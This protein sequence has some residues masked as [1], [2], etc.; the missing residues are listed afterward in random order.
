MKKTVR[1]F[2]NVNVSLP[3]AAP[4]DSR[5]ETRGMRKDKDMERSSA[6]SARAAALLLATVLLATVLL[7]Q[8]AALAQSSDRVMLMPSG[9]VSG[10]V[11]ATSPGGVDVEK[12]EEVQKIPIEKI[13]EVQFAGEPQDLKAARNLLARGRPA[14]A[15]EDLKKLTSADFDGADPLVVQEKEYVEAAA[16]A[17]A[18]L[19]GGGDVKAAGG[20]VGGF[21]AKNAKSHHTFELQELLGDLLA[22]AGLPDKA[23]AA[24]DKVAQ[25]PP[26]FKVRAAS[27]KAR[28]LFDQ[29][30]FDEAAKA[31]D[32][33]MAVDAS[34][35]ASKA[36]KR[37]AGLGKAKCFAQAGKA[38]EAVSLVLSAI[39]Q[40]SPEE[41]EMLAG[42]YNTLGA[43]QRAAGKDQDALIAFLT[44]DLVYN[45]VP[46][47][48]A[49]AL[50]N[51]V[52]LWQKANNP[53][54]SR[55]A[56]QSLETTYP[57]SP[58]V[59]SAKATVGKT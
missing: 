16:S 22:K 32:E 44:V 38:A 45:S 9:S 6:T 40:A 7:S 34:D 5:S 21:L 17:R 26:A 4:G 13:R 27:A 8:S 49:E 51:L 20:L 52:E 14:D 39:R 2:S 33:A 55:Q 36:Q 10:K 43:A 28:I 54:R 11:V 35:D 12:G 15:I 25:G 30:K 47:A 29:K 56:M 24:Y 41:R 19:L 23:A 31:F 58:W 50:A 37:A 18:A 57:D 1:V 48:H 59:K 53:E 3:G 42:A 46:E